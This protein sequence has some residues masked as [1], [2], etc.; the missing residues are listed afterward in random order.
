MHHEFLVVTIIVITRA[1]GTTRMQTVKTSSVSTSLT[2]FQS[3]LTRVANK[4]KDV[5]QRMVAITIKTLVH[6]L[7]N[8]ILK[9]KMATGFTSMIKV[10]NS[11]ENKLSMV[12]KSTLMISLV[13]KSRDILHQMVNT[14]TK[15]LG[16][17]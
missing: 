10:I 12:L 14:M 1:T 9:L 2:T 17:S 6:L 7:Q 4:S 16:L 3:T 11:R 5:L 15:I 8:A 13:H